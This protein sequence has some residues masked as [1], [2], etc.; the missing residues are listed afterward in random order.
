MARQPES[1]SGQYG[2]SDALLQALSEC[3]T[4]SVDEA[5]TLPPAVY[6]C[7]AFNRLEINKLFSKEW[8]C[9]GRT[10]EIREPGDFVTM[11]IA[12]Q[13]VFAIRQ[14]DGSIKA[15]ANT[16]L[17]RCAK[18]LKDTRGRGKLRF[19]CPYHAWT[20]D[21]SGSLLRAPY[22]DKTQGFTTEG[23]QLTELK[24]DIW[25]GFIYV[26]LNADIDYKVSDRLGDL[27]DV[28]GRYRMADYIT[29]VHDDEL[30]NTNWKILVENFIEGYHLFKV[31]RETFE[32]ISP[33]SWQTPHPGHD[34][35]TYSTSKVKPDRGFCVT[36][37][38]NTHL[39]GEWRETGSVACV[40]P[41][42][43]IQIT[44]DFLWYMSIQPHGAEQL[45]VRRGLAVAPERLAQEE[46]HERFYEET[47]QTFDRVN[48]EDKTAVEAVL[49]GAKNQ[50]AQQSLMSVHETTLFDFGR[51]LARMLT[52]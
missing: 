21:A 51:Y 50:Y 17:H 28:Y 34:A 1:A 26:T 23:R 5:L 38:T 6:V 12:E 14:Q 33:T 46:D 40:F 9:I 43:L 48:L 10:E 4:R 20:Y 42:H 39:E 15:F 52:D 45:R 44:G 36:P 18:L 19:A 7:D 11:D 25:Q 37:E 49:A 27:A 31:H 24:L 13:P 47:K 22:M 8:I 35:F 41:A 2:V 3:K 30:W 32:P 16:C 29:F